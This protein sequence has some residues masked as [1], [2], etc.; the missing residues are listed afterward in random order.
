MSKSLK[1]GIAVLAVGACL[2]VPIVAIGATG[3]SAQLTGANVVNSNGGDPDGS[4]KVTLRVNRVKQRVCYK[5]KYRKLEAQ[6][7]GA[8][9]HKGSSGQIARPVFALFKGDIAS[10]VHGCVHDV[11]K[12]IVRRLKRKP[13]QHYVDI[14]TRN[15]PN[16]AVRGQLTR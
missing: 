2:A 7:T 13:S 11:R 12:R 10:P 6:V 16:G 1:L 5:I 14:D 3:I 15:F 8:F 9:L 4:A